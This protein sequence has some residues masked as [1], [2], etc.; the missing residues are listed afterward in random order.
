MLIKLALDCKTKLENLQIRQWL[1]LFKILPHLTHYLGNF[2]LPYLEYPGYCIHCVTNLNF[3]FQSLS[4][5]PLSGAFITT[6]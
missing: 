1:A 4:F 5:R 3:E 2:P 6:D